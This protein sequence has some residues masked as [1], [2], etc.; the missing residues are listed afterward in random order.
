MKG[1]KPQ[2]MKSYNERRIIEFLLRVKSAT[3]PEIAEAAGI[4]V[5]TVRNQLID[6]IQE[7]SV[8]SFGDPESIGGRP[9][10]KYCLSSRFAPFLYIEF[11]FQN[12][13]CILFSLT[14]KQL[15]TRTIEPNQLETT[16]MEIL[17]KEQQIDYIVLTVPGIPVAN[18]FIYGENLEQRQQYTFDFLSKFPSKIN[19]E[20]LNDLNLSAFGQAASNNLIKNLVYLSFNSCVG[21]GIVID[22]KVYKGYQQFAGEIG[23]LSNGEKNID[24]CLASADIIERKKII[25][26]LLELVALLISPEMIVIN[27]EVIQEKELIA[28]IKEVQKKLWTKPMIL[29]NPPIEESNYAGAIQLAIDNFLAKGWAT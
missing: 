18:G 19:V 27:D 8:E 26:Y 28:G 4:S 11:G 7:K 24:E 10:E 25:N 16:L 23:M 21:T 6:L 15:L 1:V 29:L 3:K 9:A 5:T 2:N 14:G 22:G 12:C 13:R 17:K 20:I